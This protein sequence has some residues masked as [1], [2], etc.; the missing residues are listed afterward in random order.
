MKAICFFSAVS[1]MLSGSLAFAEGPFIEDIDHLQAG[2]VID[3]DEDGN[4]IIYDPSLNPTVIPLEEGADL[5][6]AEGEPGIQ[7]YNCYTRRPS[8]SYV[9]NR[10]WGTIRSCSGVNLRNYR[11]R[12]VARYSGVISRI[13]FCQVYFNTSSP[14]CSAYYNLTP[15]GAIYQTRVTGT[16]PYTYYIQ[17]LA[18]RA[19]SSAIFSNYYYLGQ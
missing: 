14:S 8:T 1:L 5:L 7:A 11:H 13:R 15:S 18:L 16:G 2:D 12:I 19:G 17:G 4:E 10:A 3:Y 6:E 9:T